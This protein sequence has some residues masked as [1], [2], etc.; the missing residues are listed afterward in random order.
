[1]VSAGSKQCHLDVAIVVCR[2]SVE[3]VEKSRLMPDR[4][5]LVRL[6]FHSLAGSV[7]TVMCVKSV[8]VMAVW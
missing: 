5:N 1:M 4:I 6:C 8:G 2:H 7:V 3:H